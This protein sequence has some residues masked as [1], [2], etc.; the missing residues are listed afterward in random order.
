MSHKPFL[1]RCHIACLCN[2]KSHIIRHIA[3][4]I[5]SHFT[6]CSPTIIIC[7]TRDFHQTMNMLSLEDICCCII[8]LEAD[9]ITSFNQFPNPWQEPS[10]G[11]S[12][13]ENKNLYTAW[14]LFLILWNSQFC[15]N[16]LLEFQWINV[17]MFWSA[18]QHRLKISHGL[19]TPFL[20]FRQRLMSEVIGLSHTVYNHNSYYS[21]NCVCWFGR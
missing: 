8:M 13:W 20:M 21:S 5:H 11:C 19:Q 17:F 15:I 12:Y 18:K 2:I 16:I 6:T 4:N 7:I 1:K 3:L 10:W 9:L 14:N